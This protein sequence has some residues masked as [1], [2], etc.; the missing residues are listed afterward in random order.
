MPE[1]NLETARRGYVHF[2]ATGELPEEDIH[3]DFVLDM[4][5]FRGW[6]E[7]PRYQGLAGY[8]EFISDWF[9]TWDKDWEFDITELRQLD[10]GRVLALI[11][12]RG[13]SRESGVPVEMKIAHIVTFKDGLQVSL[14]AYASHAEGLGAA[15]LDAKP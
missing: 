1:E 13:R 12:H 2:I 10:D 6:P 4:S 11:D 14:R 8:R 5:T 15:G 3:P 7:R 9:G